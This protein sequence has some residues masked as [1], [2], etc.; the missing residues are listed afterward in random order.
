MNEVVKYGIRF[1]VIFLF[2]VLILKRVD[3]N[4]G[5][6][7]YIHLIIYPLFIF[8]L[9][10]STPKSLVVALGFFMGLMIDMFYDSP[11]V[12]A[13]A[14][15]FTAF[16]RSFVLRILESAD[17]YTTSTI[18]SMKDFG[19]SGFIIYASILLGLHLIFYFSIEAFSFVFLGEILL[20]TIAS[21]IVSIILLILIQ[22]I[23]NR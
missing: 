4:P 17:G 12:H 5:D 18:P 3:I 2:Q 11:G 8:I 6:S 7:S 13:S 9:P 15:C 19:I 14:L 20:R 16:I 1:L 23:I 10:I 22:I 21:F